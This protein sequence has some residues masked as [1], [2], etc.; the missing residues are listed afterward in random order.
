MYIFLIII[1]GLLLRLINIDKPEGLWN[2]EYVSWYIASKPFL[3]GFWNEV[4]KQCHM[5]FYYFYLK[6]FTSCND[7]ILRLTSVLPS[8]L[9]IPVMYFIGKEFSKKNAYI[10]A[11]LASILPFLIYYS[12]EVRFYSLLFF[13]STLS[14][15]FTIKITTNQ[16]GWVGYWIS[17]FLILSTHVLGGIYVVLTLCYI[18]IKNKKI[19]YKSL[20]SL[21][22]ASLLILPLGLNILKMIPSSQW[23]GTFS[24]TNILFLL[25]DYFSPILTNKINAPNIFLYNKE[26]IFSILLII[27]TLISLYFII[28]GAFKVKGLFSIALGVIFITALLAINGKIVFITKYT[29]EIMPILILCFSLGI[30]YKID[31]IILAIFIALHIFALITPYYPS[32]IFRSEGHKLVT[33]ILNKTKNDKI[34]FTYYA[35]NRFERYLNNNAEKLHISKIN[36]FKYINN[37]ESILSGVNKNETI[38]IVILE[39]VSFIPNEYL[40]IAKNNNV[41][42][43]FITFSTIKHKLKNELIKNYSNY[44]IKQNGS[45]TVITATKLR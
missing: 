32:K 1:I 31:K 17:N 38:S 40:D 43:M 33:D 19:D 29:I 27:P 41:P 24:Y 16:K 44:S 30:N 21:S 35:P 15:F 36:R 7:I 10:C 23:W 14:L 11:T 26:I 42:E 18:F 34:L 22:I 13:F 6:P 4:L 8:L 39:S 37:P 28:K 25:S 2:D 5:P 9:S 3:D 45:W 12:Q 20:I